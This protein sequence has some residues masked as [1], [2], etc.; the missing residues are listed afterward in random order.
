MVKVMT[1][2]AVDR[3]FELVVTKY[4][5]IAEIDNKHQELNYP[6]YHNISN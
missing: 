5:L 1:S 2:N 6:T 4:L 3:V